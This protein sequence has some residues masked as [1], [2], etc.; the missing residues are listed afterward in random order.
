MELQ[1]RTPWLTGRLLC[2][3]QQKPAE[4]TPSLS[5][6]LLDPERMGKAAGTC[7]GGLLEPNVLS[8]QMVQAIC[9]AH[10][11]LFD[12]VLGWN[13]LMS[14]GCNREIQ[15]PEE[16]GFGFATG[17]NQN[18]ERCQNGQTKMQ[19]HSLKLEPAKQV[20]CLTTNHTGH[21][22]ISH[23]LCHNF[24]RL[25]MPTIIL[26]SHSVPFRTCALQSSPGH[27]SDKPSLA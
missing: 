7:A 18:A 14:C 12:T 20:S 8:V 6:L 26:G 13:W 10:V 11:H 24:A 1:V 22:A 27:T 15:R 2:S 16:A 21:Q 9:I 5:R 19:F 25:T 17:D 3:K 4:G 23:L